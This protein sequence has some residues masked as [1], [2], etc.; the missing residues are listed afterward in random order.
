MV[1]FLSP[2]PEGLVVLGPPQQSPLIMLFLILSLS[3][4]SIPSVKDT[5]T[6]PLV[7]AYSVEFLLHLKPEPQEGHPQKAES[8]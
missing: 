5:T 1:T 4:S 3:L 2:S 7:G 6:A 8:E